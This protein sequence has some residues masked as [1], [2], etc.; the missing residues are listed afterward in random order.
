MSSVGFALFL[1][2]FYCVC[3][4]F[5]LAL[6][7]Y[8]H[9]KDFIKYE[10]ELCREFPLTRKSVAPI[11]KNTALY[12]S[13]GIVRPDSND[14]ISESESSTR[15]GTPIIVDENF[16]KSDIL[17]NDLDEEDEFG[18]SWEPGLLNQDLMIRMQKQ[19]MRGTGTERGTEHEVMKTRFSKA[20]EPQE[21]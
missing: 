20:A 5:P 15:K 7:F 1:I 6:I 19:Y 10:A 3:E 9:R 11:L 2:S 17:R 16:R 14:G 12:G 8:Q 18:I 21:R 4:I 13:V